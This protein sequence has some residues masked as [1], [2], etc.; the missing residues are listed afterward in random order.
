VAAHPARALRRAPL[1]ETQPQVDGRDAPSIARH[2]I[3]QQPE[4]TPE[5]REQ[6]ERQE[7]QQP[8]D[9][10]RDLYHSALSPREMRNA[11]RAAHAF[12]AGGAADKTVSHFA[13]IIS[14]WAW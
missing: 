4:S 5:R 10:Q 13:L 6:R 11:K 2:R 1:R 8:D 9:R 12:G 7:V 14:R 3:E